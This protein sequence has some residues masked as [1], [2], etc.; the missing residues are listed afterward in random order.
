MW[1]DLF[2]V[3]GTMMVVNFD[4]V[5]R[6]EWASETTSRIF[7]ETG[8]VVVECAFSQLMDLIF[9]HERTKKSR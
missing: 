4:K 9:E 7:F 1:K 3:N 2:D 8:F 6:V 5:A